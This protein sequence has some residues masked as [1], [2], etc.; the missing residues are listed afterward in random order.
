MT[1]EAVSHICKRSDSNVLFTAEPESMDIDT[2]PVEKYSGGLSVSSMV[3]VDLG[4]GTS[5]GIIRWT[6][7]LIGCPETMAG[8]ELVNINH[9]K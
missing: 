5:Y 8:L 4:K 3:E 1:C 9:G 7:T 2:T 6:G